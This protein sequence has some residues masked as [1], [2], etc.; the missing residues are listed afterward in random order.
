MENSEL[1]EQIKKLEKTNR[2]LARA[3]WKIASVWWSLLRGAT[4]GTGI[5]IGTALLTT[6]LF[7]ILSKIEGWEFI[8]RYAHNILEILRQKPSN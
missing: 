6:L 7:F 8:G 1:T 4:Y 3:N 2:E 5:V